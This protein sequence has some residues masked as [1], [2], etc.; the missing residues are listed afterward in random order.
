LRNLVHLDLSYNYIHEIGDEI[1]SLVNLQTLNATF[2]YV[3]SIS[4]SIARLARLRTLALS[5]NYNMR[6]PAALAELTELETVNLEGSFFPCVPDAVRAMSLLANQT[7]FDYTRACEAVP[8]PIGYSQTR[9]DACLWNG[10]YGFWYKA[11][12]DGTLE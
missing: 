8:Q 5:Y 11:A 9:N 4:P 10:Y 12:C 7:Y 1:G 6:L 3:N 2:S